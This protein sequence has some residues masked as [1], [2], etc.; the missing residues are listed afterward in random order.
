LKHNLRDK[1]RVGG[2]GKG[3]EEREEGYHVDFHEKL[4][5][6]ALREWYCWTEVNRTHTI[7]LVIYMFQ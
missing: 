4:T 7:Q 2:E 3:N 5:N 1:G 6:P